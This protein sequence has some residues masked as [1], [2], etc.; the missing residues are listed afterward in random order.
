MST[1]LK[2]AVAAALLAGAATIA[3]TPPA[4]RSKDDGIERISSSPRPP[5]PSEAAMFKRD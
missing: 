3:V 1:C 5:R 4:S 2:I